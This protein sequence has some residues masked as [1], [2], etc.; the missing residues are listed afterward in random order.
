MYLYNSVERGRLIS[1]LPA[2]ILESDSNSGLR[3]MKTKKLHKD[4]LYVHSTELS[5]MWRNV[6]FDIVAE[7]PRWNFHNPH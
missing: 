6:D 5:E 2:F 1:M 4:L 3:S 7:S